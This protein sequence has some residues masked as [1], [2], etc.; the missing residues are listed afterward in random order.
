M[1]FD[2]VWFLL[3]CAL[4][5]LLISMAGTEDGASSFVLHMLAVICLGI[6]GKWWL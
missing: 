2:M 4:H 5:G 3:A 6:A 1:G